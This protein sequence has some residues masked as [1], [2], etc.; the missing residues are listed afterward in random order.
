[1]NFASIVAQNET[2]QL[3]DPAIGL[4]FRVA[5]RFDL[6]PLQGTSH[7]GVRFPGLK[8]WAKSCG[9]FGAGLLGRMTCAKH[10]RPAG[11]GLFSSSSQALRAWLLSPRLYL[12]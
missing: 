11:T 9:P 8:P 3:R 4:Y 1:M 12:S 7:R 6:A 10:I 2:G 5:T